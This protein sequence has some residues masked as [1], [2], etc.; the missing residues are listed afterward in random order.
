MTNEIAGVQTPDEYTPTYAANSDECPFWVNGEG[1]WT[2]VS[3]YRECMS[4]TVGE[5]FL[6]VDELAKEQ[7]EAR[8]V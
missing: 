2:T 8:L 4:N 1:D 7:R 6:H 3:W 5:V